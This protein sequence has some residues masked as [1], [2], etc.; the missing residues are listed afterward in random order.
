M[1]DPRQRRPPGPR[2]N[3]RQDVLS[4]TGAVDGYDQV[5]WRRGSEGR[6]TLVRRPWNRARGIQDQADS[7]WL[8][9]TTGTF[10][11]STPQRRNEWRGFRRKHTSPELAVRLVLTSLGLRYGV[12]NGD[13]PGSPDIYE[14]IHREIPGHLPPHD[15]IARQLSG[16]LPPNDKIRRFRA[17]HLPPHGRSSLALQQSPASEFRNPPK[18]IRS[19]S[20]GRLLL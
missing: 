15:E 1:P 2:A 10:S 3:R 8:K 11:F 4:C 12:N 17:G 9:P 5:L 6:S 18:T 14:P 16:H 20:W 7:R 13:L 19:P